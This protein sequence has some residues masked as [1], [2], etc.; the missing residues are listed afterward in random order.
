IK[1][2][3]KALKKQAPVFGTNYVD[4]SL[5]VFKISSGRGPRT[6][7]EI[8]MDSG[9]AKDQHFQIGDT[10]KIVTNA[11]AAYYVLV[12]ITKFGNNASLAGATVV[13]FDT[14]QAEKAVG[15]PGFYD[16]IDVVNKP[17]VTLDAELSAV[18]GVLPTNYEAVPATVAAQQQAKSVE[19]FIGYFH[20]FLLIFALISLFV[21][22]FLIA[23][24][25]SILIGQRIR[26][27]A[28]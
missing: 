8:A 22:A 17:G 11:G 9:T 2:D 6:D 1:K 27:L 13:T 4:S 25:F 15:H 18:G 16:Q 23:N 21:G 24:T 26:E 3:G 10:V 28:L 14:A 5:S 20:T 19:K 7:Q 12:G